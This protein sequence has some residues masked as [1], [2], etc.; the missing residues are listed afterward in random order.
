MGS[1]D[2]D[3][4]TFKGDKT[5]DFAE[6]VS[7]NIQYGEDLLGK[8]KSMFLNSLMYYLPEWMRHTLMMDQIDD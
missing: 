2:I 6:N 5:F 4:F 8:E 3:D 7:P 1:F